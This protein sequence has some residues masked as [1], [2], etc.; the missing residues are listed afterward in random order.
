MIQFQG[1]L[2]LI[3]LTLLIAVTPL[4]SGTTGKIAGTVTDKAT[5]E[6]LPGANVMVVGTT[7]GSAT[8]LDGQF[9]IL[10]IPPGLY[11]VSVS[12]I[13]YAKNTYQDVRVLIDQTARIDFEIEIQEIEFDEM[14]LDET[15]STTGNFEVIDGADGFFRLLWEASL[16]NP[17]VA[18]HLW[19][20][21]L[22]PLSNTS[23]SVGLFS[24]P[25]TSEIARIDKELLF[26]LAAVCQHEN[27]SVAE[28]REVINVS[29][30][31]AGGNALTFDELGAPT[32]PGT[33]VVQAGSHSY[34][35]S[36]AAATGK[37]MVAY[38]GS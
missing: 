10:N 19:L 16:G 23:I 34:R 12:V 21:A 32:D 20:E 2:P 4:W 33:V 5:G 25:S 3:M 29:A 22:R 37:I 8:D 27:L 11:D 31:F 14:L 18:T 36:V 7:L 13:G 17:R 6:P 26:T 1:K 15:R 28:L 24:E 35:I 38:L 9:S 30:D